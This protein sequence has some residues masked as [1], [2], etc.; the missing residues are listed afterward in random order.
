MTRGRPS[1]DPG[2]GR[3]RALTIRLSQAGL[4]ALRAIV[5]AGHATTLA[6]A[7]RWAIDRT[8]TRRKD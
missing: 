3:S 7:V 6:G 2:A 8:R 1:L 5:A 4:E